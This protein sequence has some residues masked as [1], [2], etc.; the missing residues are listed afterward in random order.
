MQHLTETERALAV[1]RRN[2]TDTDLTLE[3]MLPG[4]NRT[5]VDRYGR[6]VDGL[7][8][9]QSLA[10]SAIRDAE[11]GFFPIAVGGGKS[12]IAG[13]AGTI[14]GKKLAIILAPARTVPQLRATL[15]DWGQHFRM[16]HYRVESYAQLSRPRPTNLLQDLLGDVKPED[17]VIICDE[18]HRLRY[19]S[20]A[21][22]KRLIRLF[23]QHPQLRFIGLSGTITAAGLRDFAHLLELALREK[24]PMPLDAQHSSGGHLHAWAE[25]IDVKGQPDRYH[26]QQIQPLLDQFGEGPAPTRYAEKRAYARSAFQKR[27]E[28]APGV[29]CTKK[30]ALGAS[31]NIQPLTV[32]VPEQI[33]AAI[34]RLN[35]TDTLPNGDPVVDDISKWRASRQLSAGFAYF[36]DWPGGVPDW[37]WLDA[38]RN[39]D[40]H[41]RRELLQHS[42]DGYDSPA[43]VERETRAGGRPHLE[44]PLGE[45]LAQKH[46]PQPPT[47]PLWLS[48]FLIQAARLWVAQQEDPVLVWYESQ[49]VAHA[50]ATYLPVYGAGDE[51]P[52][53]VESCGVSI[54]AQGEGLNLH[55][56]RVSLVLEPPSSGSVWEQMLGRTHRPGQLA[57]EVDAHVFQHTTPY[58]DAL[59]KARSKSA[60]IEATTGNQQKLCYATWLDPKKVSAKP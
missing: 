49:A 39:W 28:S 45:W 10:L 32:A 15:A 37:D 23:Q 21:R 7:R 18:M 60:Y 56:W 8:P 31:L 16:P 19:L 27:L 42:T 35:E 57:D 2:Y 25:V 59:V 13:L 36:W 33:Q 26:W 46:K 47:S 50:L 17:A 40:S 29:V 1:P 14:L 54:R 43:L 22:T 51:A 48:D 4:R 11:G 38:K 55:D 53:T 24:A 3:L 52:P 30:T 20:S 34:R 44:A 58:Q 12:V 41:V 6:T 9:I 5:W